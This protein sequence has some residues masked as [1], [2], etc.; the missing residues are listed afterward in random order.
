MTYLDQN[1]IASSQTMFNRVAQCAAE[2]GEATPDVWT[3]E[4]RRQWAATPGWADA[5]ASAQASHPNQSGYDPGADDAVITD[6]MILA[7]VQAMIAAETPA[8]E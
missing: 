6:G 1:E 5:W 2:Q 3:N 4:H 7:Q 8:E